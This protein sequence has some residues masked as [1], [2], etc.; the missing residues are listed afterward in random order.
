MAGAVT[1]NNAEAYLSAGLA[2][3]GLIQVPRLSVEDLLARGLLVEVLPAHAAPHMP[4]TLVYAHQR[5]LSR[6][7]RLVMDW[8]ADVVRARLPG[9]GG[10]A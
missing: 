9:P 8:L 5:N 6:R 10:G 7:V 3:L 2:G 4:L 1:V